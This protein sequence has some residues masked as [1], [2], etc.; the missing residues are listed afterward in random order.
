MEATQLSRKSF[1][2]PSPQH[3]PFFF[4]EQVG[5]N[6]QLLWSKSLPT[7]SDATIADSMLAQRVRDGNMGMVG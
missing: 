5:Q 2:I 7:T 6:F 4:Y 1:L 3:H